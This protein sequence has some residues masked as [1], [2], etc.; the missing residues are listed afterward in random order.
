MKKIFT[1]EKF[2]CTFLLL[3]IW[4]TRTSAQCDMFVAFYTGTSYQ[5]FGLKA[6]GSLWGWGSNAHYT[7]GDGTKINKNVPTAIVPGTWKAVAAASY[8]TLAIQSNGTLWAWGS[9]NYGE[10][11]DGTRVNKHFPIQIGTDTWKAVAGGGR[12]SVGIK[13]DGT[14]W[15]WGH[16]SH[17]QLGDG[18]TEARY[19]PVQVG[20]DADWRFIASGD[21]HNMAIKADS[22]LW[23][24]GHNNYGQ[25]GDFS[26]TDRATPIQVGSD[27]WIAVDG[28]QSHTAAI[29]ADGTLWAWGLNSNGQLG[30]NA[31]GGKH[32]PVKIGTDTWKAITAGT[33]FTVGIKSDG[34]LWSWGQNNHGQLGIGAASDQR[35]PVL[36][37][38]DEWKI[39]ESGHDHT[40]AMK[41]D[42]SLWTWGHGTYGELGDGTGLSKDTPV[43]IVAPISGGAL[44]ADGS[45]QTI[46]GGARHA[47]FQQN[48][49]PIAKVSL[50]FGN[51]SASIAAKVWVAT[52][53][54]AQFVKRHFEIHPATGA[55]STA[56]EVTLYFTQGEFDDFNAVN[57]VKLP[58]GPA[59]AANKANVRVEKRGG[60]SSDGSGLPHTYAGAPETIDPEDE[61]IIWNAT[62]GYWEVTFSV[63]GFSGFF[64]KNSD[65]ALPAFFENVKAVIRSQELHL[66]WSTLTEQN[67]K[68]FEIE[69]S[70]DGVTFFKIDKVLSKADQG[71][72]TRVLHYQHTI[73]LHEIWTYASVATSLLLFAGFGF[74]RRKTRLMRLV[75]SAM[76]LSV[77]LLSCRKTQG[78]L[79]PDEAKPFFIR[80]AQ[81]DIDGTKSYSK[82][83][84]AIRE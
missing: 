43:N 72:S 16:N 22:T 20:T 28:G 13:T 41:A 51:F 21:N 71:G 25:L 26:I 75:F 18:T 84:E 77:V 35:Q 80:I 23:V 32:Y 12:H 33:A 37:S 64:L 74:K 11:G 57:T 39:V 83:I 62:S 81:V 19:T 4:M 66:K 2:A 61:H 69:G 17:S 49:N 63:N 82:I 58:T 7:L 67:N 48:C 53:Q 59:D 10:L 14:L 44:A 65:G 29:K 9:N 54:P 5:S 78:P 70:T 6:D 76:V 30:D 27:K 15:A 24:W 52:S 3:T 73:A 68:H 40:A 1:K 36:V 47:V 79:P 42:G 31:R 56:G 8:H 46:S 34:T 50:P 55:A 45:S 38:A 60:V